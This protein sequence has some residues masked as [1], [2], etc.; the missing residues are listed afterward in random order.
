MTIE[1]EALLE[2]VI[3]EAKTAGA[4][5][6]DAVFAEGI[7]LSATWR[8]G[9]AEDLERSEAQD[10]GLRV[11]IGK[12]Q[13]IV[14][15]SDHSTA[16]LEGLA[17]RAVAMARLVPEDP[18]CGLA[19]AG[20]LAKDWPDLALADDAEPS[21]DDLVARARAAED[22]ARAVEGITNS[23]GGAASWG[24]SRATLAT[25]TGFMGG[26]TTTRFTVSAS[27]L[28]GQGTEMERDYDWDIACFEADLEDAA[29]IGKR[30]GERTI[31]RLN[32]RKAQSGQ[33]PVV[34]DPRI[35]GGLLR[36]FSG[37]ISG[38]AIA[39]GT[40][41]LKDQ[42]GKPVFGENIDVI[43][44]PHRKR[45]LRS[46]PF[47]GEGVPTAKRSFVDGG[48][49]HSWIL[50]CR[51]A[52]QLGL[53][54]TGHAARGT[55]GP[56]SPSSSNLYIAAGDVAPDALIADIA[57]GFYVTE[58]IG[59]GVNGVTGD[60]S[61]GASGFWIENGAISYPV[62][63]L[64]VAGNLKDMFRNVTPANDLEFRFGVDAPTLRVEGLTV[65]GQ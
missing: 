37:A 53:E 32:P 14:S 17:E 35:S 24:R 39:R 62:S 5:A 64:T 29:E 57:S 45:G 8:L 15:T 50:D 20:Q 58:L 48:V 44:D 28:A 22:A 60:Y 7:S 56:P 2:R 11:L 25:S 1:A 55:S 33:V 63:E 27:V 19:D 42:M 34:Y 16:G 47:D 31:R 46:R 65:A 3:D 9:Q 18:Y 40:S 51:S 54:T 49:L 4:D 12:Q 13:A 30:A 26:Y 59:M 21:A 10:L 43:D 36:H 6:A 23:E 61:R 38:A 41:F 52:R